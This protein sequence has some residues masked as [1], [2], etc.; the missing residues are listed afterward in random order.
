MIQPQAHPGNEVLG[1][2]SQ[3]LQ[4]LLLSNV[5]EGR[6]CWE[7]PSESASEG[8]GEVATCNRAGEGEPPVLRRA[9]PHSSAGPGAVSDTTTQVPPGQQAPKEHQ[10]RPGAALQCR[11]CPEM[12]QSQQPRLETVQCL[13]FSAPFTPLLY[14]IYKR[15][16][17]LEASHPRFFC[18]DGG[19]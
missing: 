18:S 2:K 3:Q 16:S 7:K 9:A 14:S 12:C 6:A 13:L 11:G 4:H 8:G 1:G 10:T 5:E 17:W 15:G 19:G